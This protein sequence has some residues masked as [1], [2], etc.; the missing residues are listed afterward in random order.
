MSCVVGGE[1]EGGGK[2]GVYPGKEGEETGLAVTCDGVE[3]KRA[4]NRLISV[5]GWRGKKGERT[6]AL[7]R[8][9]PGL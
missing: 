3:E 4:L 5:T 2:D 9:R 1:R 6:G 8:E 7:Y